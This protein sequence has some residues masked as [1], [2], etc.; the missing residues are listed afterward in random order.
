MRSHLFVCALVV[1]ACQEEGVRPAPDALVIEAHRGPTGVEVTARDVSGVQVAALILNVSSTG[2]S[3][4]VDVGGRQIEH[5]S[6]GLAPLRLPLLDG[7]DDINAF[8]SDPRVG[9]ALAPWGVAFQTA[10]L[11]ARP[12]GSRDCAGV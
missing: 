12:T 2:R 5:E 3:L 1:A 7:A 8:L 6:T 9:A 10:K 11:R 4:V